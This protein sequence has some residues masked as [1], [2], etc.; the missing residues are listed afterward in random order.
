LYYH[1]QDPYIQVEP[2]EVMDPDEEAL[3]NSYLKELKMNGLVNKEEKIYRKI[4]SQV[5]TDAP[6]IIPVTLKNGELD[7]KR[8]SVAETRQ[9][10]ELCNFVREK[11]KEFGNRIMAGDLAL[12]P[13][14]RNG[15]TGC[16]YCSF[17]SVCGFDKK[18]PGYEYRRLK[19]AAPEDIW[20][21]K[22]R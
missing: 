13:Y 9:F 12:N 3:Q 19:E 22:G 1:I 5:G 2:G 21:E 15:K 17:Q 8:S 7:E 4:D 18:T 6:P 10:I 11:M 16:D 14:I 20:G